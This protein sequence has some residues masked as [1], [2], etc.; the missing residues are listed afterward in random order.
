MSG[1][2]I[3]Y[4]GNIYIFHYKLQSL[5]TVTPSTYFGQPTFYFRYLKVSN[6][7]VNEEQCHNTFLCFSYINETTVFL[8]LFFADLRIAK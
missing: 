5:L 1:R 3:E 8:F 2:L 4:I 6:I 7:N